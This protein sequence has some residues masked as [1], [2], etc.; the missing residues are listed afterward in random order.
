MLS[1]GYSGSVAARRQ[2]SPFYGVGVRG[3]RAW[4]GFCGV[5]GAVGL[6]RAAFIQSRRTPG[7]VRINRKNVNKYSRLFNVL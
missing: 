1:W 7:G 2:N 4:E 5:C 6:F 3:C